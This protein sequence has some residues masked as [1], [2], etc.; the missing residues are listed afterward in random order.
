MLLIF[1]LFS[2]YSFA[3][4]KPNPI[5]PKIDDIPNSRIID[6]LL[7]TADEAKNWEDAKTSAQVQAQIA[8]VLWELMP[9]QAEA[10]LVRA[11]E[12]SKDV[13]E[14]D[15]KPSEFRNYS[16]RLAVSREVLLVAKKRQSTLAEKWLKEFSE[17]EEENFAKRNKGKFDDRTAKSSV[18]LEM[19]MQVAENDVNFA[20]SLARES[21]ADGISFGFQSVLLKIQEKNPE[22]AQ[23]VFRVALQRLEN[24]GISDTSEILILNSYVYTPGRINSANTSNN[25]GSST[26]AFN[27]DQP[28]IKSLAELNPALAKEFLQVSANAI[29]KLPFPTTSENPE[30]A[31]R[32]QFS[33]INAILSRLKNQE[34]TQAL[35]QRLNIIQ[36]NTNYSNAPQSSPSDFAPM[37]QG[38]KITEYRSRLLDEAVEESEKLT[39]KLQRDIV[40]AK[41]CVRSDVEDYEKAKSVASK[42]DDKELKEQITNFLIYRKC[43]SLIKTGDFSESY[44]LLNKNTEPKQKAAILIIGGQKLLQDKN[45]P[46]SQDWFVDARNLAEKNKEVDNDWLKLRFGLVSSYQV[47]DKITASQVFRQ[48]AKLITE[49][50]K[51]SSDDKAPLAISFEGFVFSDFTHGTKGFSLSSAINSFP[52][53]DFEDALESIQNIKNSSTKGFATL[54]LCK[55]YLKK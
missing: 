41:A 1:F 43:L 36:A 10:I 16:K 3:Q 48:T 55:K 7:G 8:D 46:Q 21:L 22:L 14:P 18:L 2:G 42:I 20:A 35:Q 27:R 5:L 4:N 47:T 24:F 50:I 33:V 11:W 12:K 13:Q 51:L 53:Q 49:E 34:L 38:E 40:L 15:E 39:N 26:I 37:R 23:T 54:E 25:S 45:T 31:S 44:K 32:E 9:I 17:S 6:V 29:L 30:K 19:A 28:T 52:K